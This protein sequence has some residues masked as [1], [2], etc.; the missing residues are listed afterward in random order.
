MG[1]T[2]RHKAPP[3]E[4]VWRPKNLHGKKRDAAGERT[5]KN[6][7]FSGKNCTGTVVFAEENRIHRVYARI[8]KSNTG[9]S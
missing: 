1:D 8:S 9:N 7:I 2:H 6:K 5:A 4:G 3:K